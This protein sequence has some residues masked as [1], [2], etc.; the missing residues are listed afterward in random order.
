MKNTQE[1]FKVSIIIPIYNSQEYLEE[2]IKSVLSQSYKNIEIIL[3][4]D[5]SVDDSFLI[6][7]KYEKLNSNVLVK[8]QNNLGAVLARKTGIENATGDYITFVDSD[9]YVDQDYIEKLMLNMYENDLVTSGL[10]YGNNYAYDGILP[11]AYDVNI[12][13]PVIKNMIYAKDNVNIGILTNMCGK[14]FKTDLVKKIIQEVDAGIYYGE[15]GEFVYKYVLLCKKVYISEYCGYH[16]RLNNASV[17]HKIHED[18]LINVNKLYLSLKKT[19]EKSEY[20]EILLSQL[21][22]WISVHIRMAENKMGFSHY[23]KS[24]RYII[25]C[26]K[27]IANKNIVIY[28][29]GNVGKDYI[30]QIIKEDLCNSIKWVDKNWKEKNSIYNIEVEKPS[31][32]EVFNYD[33]IV[34]A[35]CNEKI[36]DE[37]VKC[38]KELNVDEKKII[39]KKPLY[40][41]EFY[42]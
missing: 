7:K 11:G 35:I 22:H 40:I 39:I 30:R 25:S 34:L 20:K 10:I 9:D 31:I 23:E 18:F 37:I 38:L 41:E 36:I 29:A 13:S 8:N 4:N 6:C 3:V 16:Y 24:I 32:I 33:Y 28:G 26:K 17:T 19:F 2:C 5:G 12:N 15:D 21:E 14:M 42:S 1:N 27:E